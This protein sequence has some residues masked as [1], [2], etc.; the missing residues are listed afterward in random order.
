MVR[1]VAIEKDAQ[2]ISHLKTA[3]TGTVMTFVKGYSDPKSCIQELEKIKPDLVLVDYTDLPSFGVD[4]LAR[5]KYAW[6]DAVK[7]IFWAEN[8][9]SAAVFAA[10]TNGVDGFVEKK[11]NDLTFLL[12]AFESSLKG[13]QSFS[14]GLVSRN[15]LQIGSPS[16]TVNS[17]KLLFDLSITQRELDV[18]RGLVDGETAISDG[19]RLGVSSETIKTH[20]A[21]IYRKLKVKNQKA[22]VKYIL[23]L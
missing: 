13:N 1:F 23:S 7:V 6:G 9:E 16:L 12:S 22:A 8:P 21:N 19:K 10:L 3:L 17:A 18:C 5:I 4:I 11:P 2:F 15:L 20:R 14:R